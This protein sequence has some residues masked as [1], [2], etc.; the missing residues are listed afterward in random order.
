M[1]KKLTILLI[2][3]NCFFANAQVSND[4]IK[5]VQTSLTDAEFQKA[6]NAY[7]KMTVTQTYISN[8]KASFL[9]TEKLNKNITRSMINDDDWSKWIVENLKKTK[10]KSV[11]EANNLRRLN[12]EL[13]KKQFEENADLYEMLRRASPEQVHEIYRPERAGRPF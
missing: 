5:E 10:F 6:I 11:E 4:S 2:T 13:T 9:M 3:L 1:K 12:L 7:L 8:K